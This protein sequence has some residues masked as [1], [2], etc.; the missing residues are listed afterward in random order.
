MSFIRMLSR[1]ANMK[2]FPLFLSLVLIIPFTLLPII[3]ASDFPIISDAWS[4]NYDVAA[5]N[6]NDGNSGLSPST[7]WKTIAKVNT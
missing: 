1:L 6:G 2:Y 7:P 5:T 3:P 4:A